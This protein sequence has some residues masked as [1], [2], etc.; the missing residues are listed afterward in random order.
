MKILFVNKFWYARGGAEIH[1]IELAKIAERRGSRVAVFSTQTKAATS[2]ARKKYLTAAPDFSGG[3]AKKT[4]DLRELFF[5]KQAIRTLQ[6]ALREF[7]PDVAHLHNVYYQLSPAIIEILHSRGVPVVMTLHDYKI[8]SPNYWL[9]DV[10]SGEVC[11]TCRQGRTL[12]CWQ[13][14]CRG[15]GFLKN[16]FFTLEAWRARRTGWYDNVDRFIAPSRFAREL[17]MERGYQ[18]AKISYLPNFLPAGKTANRESS[19]QNDQG[20]FFYM[21]RLSPEKGLEVLLKAARL[22]PDVEIRIAG[23]GPKRRQLE[24]AAQSA[25]L[26]NVKFLG[27]LNGGKL[28]RQLL[29]CRAA[30]MPSCWYENAPLSVLEA[31][32][33]AKPVIASRIGGL[34]ELVQHNRTGL[35]VRPGDE[36]ELAEAIE[37]LS[38]RRSE[39]QELG[40]EALRVATARHSPDK[41]WQ[42]LIKIYKEIS[43]K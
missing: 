26:K 7:Q 1:A 4:N 33:A 10:K 22:T 36:R 38:S 39:A 34:P 35:L 23:E 21:G 31:F 16:T 32:G 27:F 41:Y 19:A 3:P 40:A 25:R 37:H 30:V 9:Y 24:K 18:K 43:T 20:Y 29:N 28:R 42:R 12:R 14:D 2:P 17:F 5:G 11:Q 8:L 15:Q 6:Q 13:K